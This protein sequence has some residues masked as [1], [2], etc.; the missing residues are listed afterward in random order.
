MNTN[1][2]NNK[3]KKKIILVVGDFMIDREWVLSGQS[4][5]TV[6]A[7]GD[8]KPMRRIHPGWK[9]ER[10]GGAGMTLMALKA[11]SEIS[12][13]NND[14]FE[15]YGLGL[16]NQE[17]SPLLDKLA[18]A[19]YGA[20]FFNLE[21][22]DLEEDEIITIVKSRYYRRIASDQ[23]QLIHRF[24]QDPPSSN[25]TTEAR[26]AK[27]K[28]NFLDRLSKQE[29]P[30]IEAVVI[31]D[32]NKGL[33]TQDLLTKLYEK[34][35]NQQIK[36]FIDS[37]NPKIWE[38][39][40]TDITI[41]TLTINRQEA[42]DL[43]QSLQG[44]EESNISTILKGNQPNIELLSVIEKI[45]QGLKKKNIKVEKILIKLDEEGACLYKENQ[46]DKNT[47][48]RQPEK[49]LK[50]EGIAAGDFFNASLV[51]SYLDGES[52]DDTLHKACKTAAKWLKINQL[53]WSEKQFHE[54]LK[55]DIVQAKYLNLSQS[56]DEI[57]K[58]LRQKQN[59][60]S[61][62]IRSSPDLSEEE[63]KE[64]AEKI[65]RL[66]QEIQGIED[67]VQPKVQREIE[68]QEN[69][70]DEKG[71]LKDA[72]NLEDTL[73]RLKDAFDYAEIIK[74][75]N[76]SP[77][78]NVSNAK[79]FLGGFA[80]TDPLLRKNILKFKDDIK[81]H[82]I[83]GQ[84][85]PLNCIIV[86]KPGSGKSFLVKQIAEATNCEM[87]EVN[88]SQVLST[89][90][91]LQK[92]ARLQNIKYKTPLLFLDEVDAENGKYYINLLEP[93]WSAKV[94]IEGETRTWQKKF[95]TILVAS[96]ADSP[97]EFL[98]DLLTNCKDKK[99]KDLHSRLEGP[100]LDLSFSERQPKVN[101]EARTSRVYLIVDLLLR[102]HATARIAQRGILD[103]VYCAPEFNP[104][105]VEHF[106]ASLPEPIDGIIKL[107]D[108]YDKRPEKLM[109]LARNLGYGFLD[110]SDEE[111]ESGKEI[112]NKSSAEI[113]ER[114][115]LNEE[116]KTIGYEEENKSKLDIQNQKFKLES[117]IEE[118]KIH[119]YAKKE[120][121]LKKHD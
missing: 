107:K 109:K 42:Y 54:G 119:Q 37:K 51:L 103:L 61:N 94:E 3:P 85:I 102:Y 93:L 49:P 9:Y 32:F 14:D 59:N 77:T 90:D 5:L 80:S 76:Q 7:H 87:V 45:S 48:L 8:I 99:G 79:G 43:A 78:I 118:L 38:K 73:K 64:I 81:Q 100:T 83:E 82:I 22:E 46:E 110:F 2:E 98:E 60:L 41:N 65:A 50:I 17:D 40:P 84:D 70:W 34:L 57:K 75:K 1:T 114:E 55:S 39:F 95:V 62:K 121:N 71:K 20:K 108:I 91:L 105:A 19:P 21:V 69:N 47:F 36:W 28:D 33:V 10:L 12:E 89:K 58:Y 92:I 35:N 56:F 18:R 67:R 66:N 68:N 24:D 72:F 120:I 113:E 30:D 25:E 111:T 23:P 74:D 116:F 6:Q 29:I 26:Q 101:K 104:R 4:S 96:N 27:L 16:W 11:L 52:D 53:Y 63:K 86:A 15:F 106:I 88:C 31:M 97:T 117:L 115:K 13:N 44:I 112:N